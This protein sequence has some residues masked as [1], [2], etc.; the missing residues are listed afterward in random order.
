MSSL[1]DERD[2]LLRSLDDLESERAAGAIDDETY[3]TL[4]ADYTA[5][6]AA[7]LRAMRRGDDHV[8]TEAADAR[9]GRLKV[10]VWVGVVAFAVIAAV[11]LSY[12]L[13]ARLPGQLVTGKAPD[14]MGGAAGTTGRAVAVLE[15]RVKANPTD[16]KAVKDL[17]RAYLAQQQYAK[18]R[19]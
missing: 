12:A 11:S 5:R 14:A 15:A 10:G 8:A 2:F 9:A 7:V 3:A 6:A 13:G 18:A 1:Q 16:P 17:A 4:H 19:Q